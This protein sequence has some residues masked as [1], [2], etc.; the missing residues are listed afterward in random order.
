MSKL[1]RK[2]YH[3]DGEQLTFIEKY[4]ISKHRQRKE[5]CDCNFCIAMDS[6]LLDKNRIQ[7]KV[8]CQ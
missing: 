8:K 2:A 5:E 4:Y 7:D 6:S 3:Y 1:N